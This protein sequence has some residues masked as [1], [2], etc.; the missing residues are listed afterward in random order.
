MARSGQPNLRYI[1][2]L[3]YDTRHAFTLN[4]DWRYSGGDFYNGPE[5]FW[6]GVL[7]NAGVN[8]LMN[9]NS[10]SPYTS[11]SR[12]YALTESATGIPLSGQINGSRLPWQSTMDLNFNKVWLVKPKKKEGGRTKPYNVEIY[13]TIR[14]VLNKR[15]V[16]GVYSYTG[17]A[18]DDGYLSSPQGINALNFQTNAQSYTDLYNLAMAN[19]FSYSAPRQFRLG[20]RFGF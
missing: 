6:K 15:N 17:S 14:N 10:G 2:P 3:N 11:R 7:E 18:D 12:A 16:N 19:P 4:L 8:L 5:G 20:F 13:L 9:L 1:L